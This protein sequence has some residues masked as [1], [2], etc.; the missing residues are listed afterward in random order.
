MPVAGAEEQIYEAVTA[1]AEIVDAPHRFGGV[2]FRVGR[3][4][5]GHVRIVPPSVEE[6]SSLE[7]GQSVRSNWSKTGY[8]R[9][10]KWS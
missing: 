2:E 10:R 6:A 7:S 1:W 4:E 9:C 8:L 5:V 3:R